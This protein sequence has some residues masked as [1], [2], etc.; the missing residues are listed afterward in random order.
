MKQPSWYPPVLC[1]YLNLVRMGVLGLLE[2][3]Y[4]KNL[5]LQKI[6]I[7]PTLNNLPGFSFFTFQ[8]CMLFTR[9]IMSEH[10]INSYMSWVLRALSCVAV[11]NRFFELGVV[12]SSTSFFVEHIWKSMC[13]LTVN[14]ISY[15]GYTTLKSLTFWCTSLLVTY[16][17]LCQHRKSS[18]YES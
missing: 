15:D 8:S 1:S 3:I 18:K 13:F 14:C 12:I 17:F 10:K 5:K 6:L 16:T 2:P 4:L 11:I 9:S 7:Y